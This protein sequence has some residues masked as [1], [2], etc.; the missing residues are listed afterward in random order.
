M[1]NKMDD[2]D[3]LYSDKF[4]N[5]EFHSSD[6]EWGKLSSKLAKANFLKFSYSTFNIYYLT[7]IFGFFAFLVYLGLIIFP[8]TAEFDPQQ[9]FPGKLMEL[10]TV[11]EKQEFASDSTMKTS[12]QDEQTIQKDS[13]AKEIYQDAKIDSLVAKDIL[14]RETSKLISSDVK[15]SL[16]KNHDSLTLSKSDTSDVIIQQTP[17][18]KRVKKTIVIR[19]D[20]VIVT[21][22]VKIKKREK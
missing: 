8:T 9:K 14:K 22:T 17:K 16:D 13:K 7:A 19:K 21:D 6:D 11:V 1:N 12:V 20:Q 3:K 2:I 5:F 15:E 10:K 4:E 18:I